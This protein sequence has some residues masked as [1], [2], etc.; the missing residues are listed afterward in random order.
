MLSDAESLEKLIIQEW[1]KIINT[2]RVLSIKN[3]C[4]K[5]RRSSKKSIGECKQVLIDFLQ[6]QPAAFFVTS[7]Q[8]IDSNLLK[9]YRISNTYELRNVLES[10]YFIL[11]LSETQIEHIAVNLKSSRNAPANKIGMRAVTNRLSDQETVSEKS[12]QYT[13]NNQEPEACF[14][15]ITNFYRLWELHSPQ[16]KYHLRQKIMVNY[17]KG[18]TAPKKFDD[19]CTDLEIF[20]PFFSTKKDVIKTLASSNLF[21]NIYQDYWGS[22][23]EDLGTSILWHQYF[24]KNVVQSR[25]RLEDLLQYYIRKRKVFK[26]EDL[27]TSLEIIGIKYDENLLYNILK[28]KLGC[29][30]I[31]VSEWTSDKTIEYYFEPDFTKVLKLTFDNLLPVLG[32]N[33][34][35]VFIKRILGKQTLEVTGEQIGVTRERIRQL[36]QKIY[37]RLKSINYKRYLTPFYD[38]INHSIQ[39]EGII[40]LK[41]FNVAENEYNIFDTLYLEIMGKD[42]PIRVCEGIVISSISYH[43]L[44]L[45]IK[46]LEDEPDRLLCNDDIQENGLLINHKGLLEQLLTKGFGLVKVAEGVYYYPFYKKLTREEEIYLIIYRSGRPVHFTEVSELAS[47]YRLPLSIDGEDRNILATMQ[48]STRLRRVAPGTYGLKK[49]PIGDHIFLKD[50]ICMVLEEAEHPL[51]VQNIFDEVQNRRNDSISKNSV[52][53]YLFMNPRIVTVKKGYY[54]LLECLEPNDPGIDIQEGKVILEVF[55][56]KGIFFTSYQV[57]H[58]TYFSN[59]VRISRLVHLDLPEKVVVI[60]SGNNFYLENIS[61]ELLTG[62]KRWGKGLQPGNTFCLEFTTDKVIRYL[63]PQDM[64]N[65]SNI[66]ISLLIKAEQFW[67]EQNYLNEQGHERA[68]G[69]E[70]IYSLEQLIHIGLQQGYVSG[71][72]FEKVVSI[73]IKPKKIQMALDERQIIVKW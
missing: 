46:S 28:E 44:T 72:S 21:I 23:P 37:R 58:A 62:L 34:R 60:D 51:T 5:L 35:F 38:W 17:F 32:K 13:I 6:Q 2:N 24:W 73:G 14:A 22:Y 39:K 16:A 52:Y 69:T 50:L 61:S 7:N 27:L 67:H 45:L 30:R 40:N 33:E 8:V 1:Q 31:S 12:K 36:E 57:S 64:D 68:K 55:Q 59:S 56:K 4:I 42:N 20:A 25:N 54:T 49:W 65:Y 53:A 3:S 48:R 10:M 63:E 66:E 41:D 43:K 29:F 18:I 19:I 47:L 11:G 26:F 71:R 9:C 70:D 15:E